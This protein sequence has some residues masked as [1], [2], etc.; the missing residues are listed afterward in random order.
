MRHLLILISLLA[1]L[2]PVAGVAQGRAETLADIRQQLTVLFVELRQLSVELS[3]TGPATGTPP[4]Q[5][6]TL[7]DRVAAMESEV[8]RLTAK[9]EELEFRI[10]RIVSDGTNRIGDLEFRLCELETECDISSLGE[11]P[12]LGGDTAPATALAP[13]APTAPRPEQP[14]T[15]GGVVP[16]TTGPELAVGEVAEFEQAQ[17]A[18]ASGDYEVA[19]EAFRTFNE[20]YPGGPLAAAADLGRGDALERLGE[21]REAARAYLAAFSTDQLARTAPVALYKLGASLGK[22]G[23]VSEAC[24]TLDEVALRY[25]DAI[26]VISQART[27]RDE[28]GCG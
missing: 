20:S 3:T 16:E 9:A 13:V 19:A 7:L 17:Q 26:D 22:L 14:S 4:G 18:L 10:D 6:M 12:R 1:M 24:V 27:A 11:T 2:L 21:T 5:G 23:Q 25:P 8:Q 28:I 15:S